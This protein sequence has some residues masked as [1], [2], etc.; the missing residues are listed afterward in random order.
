MVR[1]IVSFGVAL[2]VFC[3]LFY[4]VRLRAIPE[5]DIKESRH[6]PPSPGKPPP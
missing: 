3:V 1:W 6:R 4:L 5:D 2:L